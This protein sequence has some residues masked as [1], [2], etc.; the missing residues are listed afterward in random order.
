M[1]KH[2]N[3]TN[4]PQHHIFF[5][6]SRSLPPHEYIVLTLKPI[7]HL[8]RVT[9]L[10]FTATL[11]SS[12]RRDTRSNSTHFNSLVLPDGVAALEPLHF[13]RVFVSEVQHVTGEPY[14]GALGRLAVLELC[15]ELRASFGISSS[16]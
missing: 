3:I 11:Y 14:P 2:N 9:W 8:D 7:Y 12:L 5:S 6:L 13:W 4:A 10:V 16:N 1:I 15:A